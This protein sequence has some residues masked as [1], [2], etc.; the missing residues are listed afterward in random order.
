HIFGEGI[1]GLSVLNPYFER[2]LYAMDFIEAP[3]SLTQNYHIKVTNPKRGGGSADAKLRFTTLRRS[4]IEQGSLSECIVSTTSRDNLYLLGS[5]YN[6]LTGVIHYSDR[7][8]APR[9]ASG[10]TFQGVIVGSGAETF[11]I[12]SGGVESSG[13]ITVGGDMGRAF[14]LYNKTAAGVLSITAV[15]D[16]SA[17]V[18]VVSDNITITNPS[19]SSRTFE[20]TFMSARSQEVVTP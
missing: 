6:F 16:T 5:D 17:I 14:V 11:T 10:K 15:S 7:V 1:F 3:I 12:P 4:I 9:Q 19:G 20:I 2:A 18:S 8:V 13:S